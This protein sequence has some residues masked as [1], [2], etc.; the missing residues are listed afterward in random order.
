MTLGGGANLYYGCIFSVDTNGN[1]Y[2]DMF[3]FNGTN[4]DNPFGSLTLSGNR[5]YGMTD[6]GGTNNDGVI[7]SFNYI[8]AGINEFTSTSGE[9]KLFPNPNNGKFTVSLKGVQEKTQINIYNILGEQVYQ[10]SLNAS[11]TQIE[12]SNKAEGLYLYRVLT[13]TGALVSEGKIVIQ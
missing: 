4:G 5:V 6:S 8:T 12:L 7:F 9:V 2:K 1:N 11:T 10:S 13:E 3:D